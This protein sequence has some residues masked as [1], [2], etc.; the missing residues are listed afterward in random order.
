[1]KHTADDAVRDMTEPGWR[2]KA[3]RAVARNARQQ[4]EE[5]QGQPP[6]LPTPEDEHRAAVR[7]QIG[8][9]KRM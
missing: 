5:A 3:E 7:R 1:M 8:I 2:A 9:V 4:A 6:T